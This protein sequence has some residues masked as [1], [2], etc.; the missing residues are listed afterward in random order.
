MPEDH[1]PESQE[2]R[3][4]FYLV[5]AYICIGLGAIGAILPL[6]PTTPFLLLAAWAAPKGSPALHRWLYQHP[7]I[8]PIL[9]AWE[10]KGAVSTRTKW[11]ACC[12]MAVSWVTIYIQTTTWVA[13]AVAGVLFF[14]V[15][16]FI[17]TR[18]TP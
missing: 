1:K 15:A 14:S 7:Q 5:F 6:M 11:F 17:L 3:N 13:P 4:L 9:V 12:L 8:G 16:T 2:R 10:Q 18:P